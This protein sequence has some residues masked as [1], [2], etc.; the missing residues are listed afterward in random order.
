VNKRKAVFYSTMAFVC[1]GLAFICGRTP[2][3]PGDQVGPL[4]PIAWIIVG[5]VFLWRATVNLKK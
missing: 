3:L 2:N 4:M 5:T 1:Y